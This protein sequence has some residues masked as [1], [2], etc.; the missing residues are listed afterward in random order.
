MIFKNSWNHPGSRLI[1][2]DIMR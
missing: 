2:Y 1:R